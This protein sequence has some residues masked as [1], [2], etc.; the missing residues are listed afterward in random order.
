MLSV[1]VS[2]DP[3]TPITGLSAFAPAD[4]PP[5]NLVFQ[6]Y[7]AMIAVWTALMALSA[8]YRPRLETLWSAV[9]QSG[10]AGA[11]EI[12]VVAEPVAGDRRFAAPE[13][14]RLPYYS[15]LKQSYLVAAAYLT[16]MAALAKLPAP[17][18]RRL[19][20]LTR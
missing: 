13:W 19:Q 17:E 12:P 16:E 10:Q 6:S 8:K 20:F 7:H 5:V 2:G 3:S 14:D 15:L 4:R 18:K 1:L 11:A 9:A